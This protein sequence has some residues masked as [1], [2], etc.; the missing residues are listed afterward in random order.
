MENDKHLLVVAGTS[1]KRQILLQQMLLYFFLKLAVQKNSG[2][3]NEI[4]F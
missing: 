4:K 3:Y 1:I 2:S